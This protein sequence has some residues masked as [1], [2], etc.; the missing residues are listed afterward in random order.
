MRNREES[1]MKIQEN[2]KQIRPYG[3]WPS[4]VSPQM[5]S[6]RIRI[7]EPQWD[8]DGKTLL[9]LEARAGQG[10][11][12]AQSEGDARR[13]LNL[14]QSAGGGVLF[15][16][17]SFTVRNGLVLFAARDGR[18]YR[19]SLGQ[20]QPRAIT[21]PFGRVASPTLSPDGRWV[22]YVFSDGHTDCLGLVDANGQ[23]WPQKLA[24][25]SDFYMQ[26]V[27]HPQGTHLTWVEWDHPNMPWY[28][29]RLKL[30]RFDSESGAIFEERVIAGDA[31]TPIM[32]PEFSPDGRWLSFIR[33]SAEWEDLVLLD[34]E[35]GAE[36]VL[37]QGDGFMLSEPAWIQGRRFYGWNSSSSRVYYIRSQQ[38]MF[39]L[40]QVDLSSGRSKQIDTGPYTF[41]DQLSVSPMRSEVTFIAAAP[42]IP[43]RIVRWD[44]S[45]LH[46]V[47]YS[48]PE[49]LPLDMM[50]TPQPIQWEAEDGT[51]VHG[52]YYPPANANFTGTGLPPAIVSIHGGPTSQAS[53]GYDSERTYFTSRGY[54]WLDVNYRGSTGYGRSYQQALNGRWGDLDVEDAAD[55][56]QALVDLELA[57][58]SQLVIRGSSAGGYTVLNSLVR[59]P[60][61]YRAGISLYGVGNLFTLVM[62]THKF[63]QHYNDRLIG[64]LPEA[65]DKF[66][67]WSTLF[68]AER[69]SDPLALFHGSKDPVVPPSQSEEIAS[70]LRA[71]GVPHLFQLYEGEGHGFRKEET[72][73]DYLRQTERFLQE[74]V[75]FAP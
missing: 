52:L 43:N 74:Q 23:G 38:S 58:G 37:V 13:D 47:A 25:G 41:L 5:L 33:G 32:Q 51:A 30:A 56:A 55:G 73:A 20:S 71:N 34:L 19:R 22:I 40:W 4:P 7:G 54:G 14:L 3:L 69:I 57:E 18:V 39:T 53:I 66:Y 10:Y 2:K 9:W 62:E 31:N 21:P 27:W 11:I 63:E 46:T 28:G 70:I 45:G 68:H 6:R 61:Q 16:G 17:G 67:G 42:D 26:P 15:G 50:S 60:G 64:V 35:S 8:S 48:Q 65:R 75:L 36:Q 49:M 12:V 59:Y 24:Q 44:D 29:S 72:I 1:E